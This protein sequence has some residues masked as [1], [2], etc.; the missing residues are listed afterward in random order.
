MKSAEEV[1]ARLLTLARSATNNDSSFQSEFF[2]FVRAYAEERVK[3][4]R[5]ERDKAFVGMI[6]R[7][8]R[9]GRADALEEAAKA[10]EWKGT[11]AGY[12]KELF[13]LLRDQLSNDIR[14]LGGKA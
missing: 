11:R 8:K 1:C 5:G 6:L 13:V 14:A 3:E 10:V 2:E 9:N 4:A 12:E 7:A